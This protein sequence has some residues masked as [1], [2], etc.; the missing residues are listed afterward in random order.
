MNFG[1]IVA[2]T[3][4]E[5]FV[6]KIETMILSGQ[7]AAGDR[8]P[9]ERE[10][11]EQMNIS[12]TAVH[13][14]LKEL[15]RK[16]FITVKGRHGTYIS[17]YSENGNFD[18]LAAIL[19]YNEGRLDRDYVRD[20]LEIRTAVE[21]QAFILFA[22]RHTEE[23]IQS[24][25][26]KIAQIYVYI[27]DSGKKTDV[28][29]LAKKFYEFHHLVCVKSKNRMLPLF[30]SSFKSVSLIFWQKSLRIFGIEKSVKMLM[31]FTICLEQG[32]GNDALNML[33][34]GE[35]YYLEKV[36]SLN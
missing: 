11:A 18:T 25:K 30:M 32:R 29:E 12:K 9:A 17:N 26:D 8:L 35:E 34:A 24:L 15:A 21:G 10:L 14:G 5:I 13:D 33:K 36:F 27:T 22:K 6:E 28:A 20:V 2:P 7:L 31:D 1:A 16:G 3:I 4:R 23:D 19:K